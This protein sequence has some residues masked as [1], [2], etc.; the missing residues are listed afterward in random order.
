MG[1]LCFDIVS[2]CDDQSSILYPLYQ[3]QVMGRR[4]HRS[5]VLTY[6]RTYVR[7]RAIRDSR[8]GQIFKGMKQFAYS[9]VNFSSQYGT[10]G[11]DS[12]VAKNLAGHQNLQ[13]K[14]GDYTEAFVLVS[15]HTIAMTHQ[16]DARR[17]IQTPI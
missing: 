12:Y 5:H 8:V 10:N 6:V 1:G 2:E 13:G 11:S 4:R 16:S 3:N 14:Y 9:V 15:L 17:H 7:T